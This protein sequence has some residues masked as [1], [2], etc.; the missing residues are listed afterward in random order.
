MRLKNIFGMKV[1]RVLDREF[2]SRYSKPIKKHDE[3]GNY[4]TYSFDARGFFFYVKRKIDNFSQRMCQ[5]KN[6]NH[7]IPEFDHKHLYLLQ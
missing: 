5:K 1:M 7:H 6:K 4:D 3:K 2:L